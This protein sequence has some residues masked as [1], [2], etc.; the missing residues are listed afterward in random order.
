[1]KRNTHVLILFKLNELELIE[2]TQIFVKMKIFVINIFKKKKNY[3]K[4]S[5]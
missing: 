2:L 3:S 1:M 4:R 5:I